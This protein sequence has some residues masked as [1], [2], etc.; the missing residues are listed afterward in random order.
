MIIHFTKTFDSLKNIIQT[1]SFNLSY[2]KEI[3]NVEDEKISSA[4]HPMVCFSKYDLDVLERQNIT[5]GKYGIAFTK[6]W[7]IENRL[8]PVLYIEKTSQAAKGLGD[9]LKARQGKLKSVSLPTELRLPIMQ[10]KCFTKNVNGYNSYLKKDNYD[11]TKENEWRY[12]PYKKDIN[13]NYISLDLSKYEENQSMHNEKI[14]DY[15]LKFKII[16]ID[17]IFVASR[18]EIKSLSES[19]NIDKCLIQ[20]SNWKTE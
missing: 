14:E 6:K 10:L 16:D 5:Y 19:I 8:N 13:G 2:C 3:F 9:L 12:I 11:F 17:K 4:A 7:A 15:P 18:F 20:E 1:L